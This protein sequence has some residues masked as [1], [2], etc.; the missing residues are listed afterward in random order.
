MNTPRLVDAVADTIHAPLSLLRRLGVAPAAAMSPED[1]RGNAQLLSL[2]ALGALWQSARRAPPWAQI[3]LA[4][5]R[6]AAQGDAD[7][8]ALCG[9]F[10]PADRVR[11][12]G[13]NA[14]SF[15]LRAQLHAS[16]RRTLDL[17]TYYLQR[18]DTGRAVVQQL[19]AAARRGVRVRVVA[20]AAIVRK[21][22]RE[23]N[24]SEDLL[25]ELRAGGVEVRA[26]H[27]PARPF[28]AN[29]RKL[30]IVDGEHLL[31]GGRNIADHYAGDAWRDVEVLVQGP[32][33]ATAQDLFTRTFEGRPEPPAPPAAL[34]RATTPRDLAAHA[35]FVFLLRCLRSARRS[36]D[37]ENAYLFA[38]PALVRAIAAATARGVRVRLLTNS[39]ESNDLDFANYR[40]Y[41][42]FLPLLDAGATLH[43]RRGRGRTLHCKYFVADGRWVSLG[44][45]N[46]DYYSPRYC[47]EANLQVR[48]EALGVALTEWF[49]EG[50][51][52]AD[53]AHDRDGLARVRDAQGL[54]RVID[55][56]L[57]DTQ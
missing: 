56:L 11:V 33:A 8:P 16:A 32:G 2:G 42:G 36:V 28:D 55:R 46:L 34:V 54:G 1:L 6:A 10:D 14:R 12:V 52:D 30:L 43:L 39:A 15:A 35:T 26:W 19:L 49:E 20:D 38:H 29:H 51:R 22:Q 18:D 47:T 44:S 5:E 57:R 37:V 25:A 24:G 17:S 41:T 31:L 53:E 13:D 23:G 7:D 48:S 21:K 27:D 9:A 45:T 4:W 40:L 3:S 50:L